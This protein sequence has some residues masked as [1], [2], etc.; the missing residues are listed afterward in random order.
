MQNGAS[1]HKDDKWPKERRYLF[2]GSTAG[3]MTSGWRLWESLMVP[4]LHTFIKRIRRTQCHFVLGKWC[5]RFSRDGKL[6]EASEFLSFKQLQGGG[7]HGQDSCRC[8]CVAGDWKAT[9][10]ACHGVSARKPFT[11][12]ALVPGFVLVRRSTK[13]RLRYC[14]F[15]ALKWAGIKP[16]LCPSPDC[17]AHRWNQI[18]SPHCSIHKPTPVSPKT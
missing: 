15:I 7:G 13:R 1:A 14:S 3:S 10:G 9:G 11:Q 18:N 16:P 8:V 6:G 12:E 4:L 17:P 2:K 5:V